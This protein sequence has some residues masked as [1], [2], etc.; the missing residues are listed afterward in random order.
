MDALRA[1]LA[2]ALPV[3]GDARCVHLDR[4]GRVTWASRYSTCPEAVLGTPVRQWLTDARSFDRAMLEA[5]R[6]GVGHYH[7]RSPLDGG[8]YGEIRR[9]GSGYQIVAWPASLASIRV[10]PRP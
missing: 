9:M 1:L 2:N 10:A 8:W 6:G 3:E 4:A 7:A 5:D